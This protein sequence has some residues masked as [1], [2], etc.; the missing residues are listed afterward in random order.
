MFFQTELA[1]ARDARN[2]QLE[3]KWRQNRILVS[4]DDEKLGKRELY[5]G[6]WR[7][8]E[9]NRRQEA[10]DC[11]PDENEKFDKRWHWQR[12]RSSLSEI[13]LPP[14]LDRLLSRRSS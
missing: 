8:N 5:T 1:R 2:A 6:S 12:D 13:T 9:I 4:V 7:V 10:R 14:T 11:E 3:G